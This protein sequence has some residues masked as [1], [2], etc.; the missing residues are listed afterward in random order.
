M[1]YVFFAKVTDIRTVNR[2]Y[3]RLSADHAPDR[4]LVTSTGQVVRMSQKSFLT[5]GIKANQ[6]RFFGVTKATCGTYLY[7]ASNLLSKKDLK[8][9]DLQ[10][11]NLSDATRKVATRLEAL[12]SAERTEVM[13]MLGIALTGVGTISTAVAAIQSLFAWEPTTL[14][15]TSALSV[16]LGALTYLQWESLNANQRKVA[17]AVKRFEEARTA[18]RLMVNTYSP[19]DRTDVQCLDPEITAVVTRIKDTFRKKSFTFSDLLQWDFSFA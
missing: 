15:T 8:A 11:K 2:M 3:F 4:E 5:S 13:Q 19:Y 12:S 17:E 7:D 16:G 10:F 14:A 1:D 18:Y 6:W 9:M